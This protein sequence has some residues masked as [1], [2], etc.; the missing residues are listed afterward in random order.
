MQKL[1]VNVEV[2]Y[3]EDRVTAGA[4][5]VNKRTAHLRHRLIMQ[6][7]DAVKYAV[8]RE[9]DGG[10]VCQA[11]GDAHVHQPHQIG[12]AAQDCVPVDDSACPAA[13]ETFKVLHMLERAAVFLHEL[14][15]AARGAG[16]DRRDHR[17][18]VGDDVLCVAVGEYAY[19]LHR[20][21]LLGEEV[22]VGDDDALAHAEVTQPRP[23][24][25]S[26]ADSEHARRAE[27]IRQ[28]K[29]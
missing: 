20:H 18:G 13:G 9:K 27:E 11:E 24:C 2:T 12:A 28:R 10:L 16:A 3:R 19:A 22:A 26:A 15:E 1:G 17:P 4:H 8:N 25:D 5:K 29:G 6:G 7:E 14:S 21:A 23:A